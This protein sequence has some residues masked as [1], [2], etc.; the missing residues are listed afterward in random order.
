[1]KYLYPSLENTRQRGLLKSAR[2]IGA[3]S[4]AG[5]YITLLVAAGA[6][7]TQGQSLETPASI[8]NSVLLNGMSLCLIG[9]AVSAIMASM[10]KLQLN[11][12]IKA[13]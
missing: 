7:F 5:F 13:Q 2:L 8:A 9:W 6:Y 4:I 12:A 10:V 11:Q 1:M 3:L